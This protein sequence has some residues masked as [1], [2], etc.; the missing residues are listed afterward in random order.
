MSKLFY[1]YI[2]QHPV[3]ESGLIIE[4]VLYRKQTI[5]TIKEK[6]A[7]NG[8]VTILLDREEVK[9]EDYK[10]VRVKVGSKVDIIPVVGL[11]G[12]VFTW[13]IPGIIAAAPALIAAFALSYLGGALFRQDIKQPDSPKRGENG[14]SFAWNPRTTKRSEIPYPRSWGRNLHMGNIVARWT[15]IDGSGDEKLYMIL[16]YGEG[17]VEGRVSGQ[18]RFNDQPVGNFPDV[19]IQSRNGT[20]DQTCMTGFE[21]NKLEYSSKTEITNDGGALTF[22]TPNDFFDDIEYTLEFNKGLWYYDSMGGQNDHSIGVR[23]QISVRGASSWT[24]I[25]NTT[26]SAN[27]MNPLYKA[28]KVSDQAFN[29]VR[30]NQYDLKITKTTADQ[31]VARYGDVFSL[32]TVREVVDVA[33]TRPGKV[34]LGI[35]ALATETLS[36]DFD[37]KCVWD[38][39]LVRIYNGSTWSIAHSRNRAWAY[40]DAATQPVISGNGDSIPY[41]VERYEGL[42]PSKIDLAGIYEWAEWC[43]T[44]VADGEGGLE[45]RMNCDLIVDYQTSLWSL[46]H[47]IAQIGRYTSYWLGYTLTGWFD[48]VVN[49]AIDLVTFDNMMRDSWRNAWTDKSE[50]AGTV[51][52]FYKDDLQ[53][54]ERKSVPVSNENSGNYSRMVSLEGTGV[55]SRTLAIRMGNHVLNRNQLIRNVNNF[56]MYKDA[57]RYTLG[58]VIRLQHKTPDWGKSYQVV[59]KIDNNT[60]ELDRAVLAD[61][62][63]SLYLRTYDSTA[64]DIDVSAY[65]IASISDTQ[66][67]ITTT[68]SIDP[69]KHYIVA[70]GTTKLRRIIKIEPT[71]DNYFEIT[72]ETYDT[73][74]FDSDDTQPDAPYPDHIWPEADKILN[75]PVTWPNILDTINRMLPPQPDIEI[76]WLSNIDW[77]GNDVD[78]VEWSGHASSGDVDTLLFRYRGTTYEITTDDTTKEFI[79]WDPNFTDQFRSTDTLSVAIA[80]GMWMVCIN[81]SGVAY[82]ANPFQL[83]HAGLLLAGTIRAESYAELRQTYVYNGDDSLDASKPY[84]IPFKIVSEM[85]AIVSMKLSFRL[86]P[87]RAYSTAASSGGADTSGSGGDD[88]TGVDGS[89]SL[90]SG[91][92]GGQTSGAGGGQTSSTYNYNGNHAHANNAQHDHKVSGVTESDAGGDSHSHNISEYSCDTDTYNGDATGYTS[93]WGHDHDINDHTHTVDNHQHSV[94]IS[95]HSHTQPTHTHTTPNH[96]HGITYGIHEESNSPTVHFHIDNGAGF[97]APSANYNADQLDIDISGSLSGT[98]WKNLRFDTNLRCRIVAIIE[99]KLDVTA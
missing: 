83:I 39:R 25:L 56:K 21:Q 59:Q 43:D 62:G 46:T 42:N 99:L 38:D 31:D 27:Q 30:G 86:M 91:A 7:P 68:W 9:L 16:C 73:N 82:P 45:S 24:T 19:T 15:D 61:V 72:V 97:G 96:V 11:F 20:F 65:E 37:V 50:L 88:T 64:E 77:T 80:S 28:Y 18:L 44:Q 57:V 55:S 75:R 14:Q 54:W 76:P 34:L 98:G 29:C 4:D 74:L 10:K 78:T 85:T 23:V 53:G 67:T 58:D 94:D 70:I 35:T 84:E 36:G 5:Q 92:G 22:I 41:S 47:E 93:G 2:Y 81:K 89:D 17:P 12:W 48:G 71:T 87:Y 3:E 66:V 26:I 33:F 63:D 13:L 1:V 49:G 40:L 32:R 8:D 90:T 79:Y 60:V 6:F 51:E 95:N 52:V 69:A